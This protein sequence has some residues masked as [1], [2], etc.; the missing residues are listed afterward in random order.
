MRSFKLAVGGTR[1]HLSLAIV[2][3]F[4]YSLSPCWRWWRWPWRFSL[5]LKCREQLSQKSAGGRVE[6]SEVWRGHSCEFDFVRQHFA[7]EKPTHLTRSTSPNWFK[8]DWYMRDLTNVVASACRMRSLAIYAL[9]TP[10]RLSLPSFASLALR[11]YRSLPIPPLGYSGDVPVHSGPSSS[12]L[13]P[14]VSL[15]ELELQTASL[16]GWLG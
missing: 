13:P 6:E 5:L 12:I 4:P 10:S 15:Q 2:I 14:W 7:T 11:S 16:F 1:S 8:G 3:L 9:V